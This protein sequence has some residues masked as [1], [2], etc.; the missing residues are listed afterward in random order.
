[1]CK[2]NQK[3]IFKFKQLKWI[4]SLKMLKIVC[5]AIVHSPSAV[6]SY[7]HMEQLN[8]KQKKI[9]KVVM[10]KICLI[11]PYT[12]RWK[13]RYSKFLVSVLNNIYKMKMQS[14]LVQHSIGTRSMTNKSIIVPNRKLTYTQRHWESIQLKVYNLPPITVREKYTY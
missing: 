7:T 4:I 6:S 10:I 8:I 2:R 9:L 3:T 13:C 14:L 1:M 11:L 12:F 5:D